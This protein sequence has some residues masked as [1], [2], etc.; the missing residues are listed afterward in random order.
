MIT[1]NVARRFLVNDEV[2]HFA[3]MSEENGQLP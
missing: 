3:T 2:G 1:G